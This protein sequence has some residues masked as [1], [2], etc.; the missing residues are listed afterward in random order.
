MLVTVQYE[1]TDCTNCIFAKG[2]SSH[3][4]CWTECAHKDHNRGYHENILWGCNQQFKQVPKWCPL[5]IVTT[6]S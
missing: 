1:I 4:E 2:H 5:G 6:C 3:G